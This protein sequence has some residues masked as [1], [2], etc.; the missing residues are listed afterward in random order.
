MGNSQSVQID[1]DIWNSDPKPRE[2]RKPNAFPHLHNNP[3]SIID[4]K[5]QKETQTP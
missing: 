5:L 2:N 3:D 4:S 1:D